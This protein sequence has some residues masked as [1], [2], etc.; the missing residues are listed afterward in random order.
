MVWPATGDDAF[1]LNTV[2]SGGEADIIVAGAYGHGRLREWALGGVT[3]DLLSRAE[4]CALLS[5]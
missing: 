5:H 1:D 3:H 4:R 2:A